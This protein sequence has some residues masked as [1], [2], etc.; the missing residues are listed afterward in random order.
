[1]YNDLLNEEKGF[2]YQIA[3]KIC[4]KKYKPTAGIEFILV[5]FYSTTKTV[6][7]HQFSIENTFQE[8]LHMMITGLIKDLTGLLN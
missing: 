8:I 3:H 6:I 7:N 2:K 1:M 5:Y 4:V